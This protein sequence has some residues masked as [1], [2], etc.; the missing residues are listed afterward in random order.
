[1][2]SEPVAITVAKIRRETAR[3]QTEGALRVAQA[4][5]QGQQ[6]L[7]TQRTRILI[8]ADARHR[9]T[10]V[11]IERERRKTEKLVGANMLRR[12][13]ERTK[14]AIIRASGRIPNAEDLT[15]ELD[16]LKSLLEA[17]V[18]LLEKVVKRKTK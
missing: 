11:E 3:I 2:S 7:D 16:E 6:A 15:A 8:D 5:I 10:S 13:E 14:Q 1:M 4:R 9:A 18:E 17:K 12:E